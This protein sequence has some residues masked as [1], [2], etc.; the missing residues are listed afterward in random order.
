MDH[1][2]DAGRIKDVNYLHVQSIG[3]LAA[4]AR[5]FFIFALVMDSRETAD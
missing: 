5:N 1:I 3:I 4:R 2:D